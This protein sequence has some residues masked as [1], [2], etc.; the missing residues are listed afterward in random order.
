MHFPLRL[1]NSARGALHHFLHL[2]AL[3][4]SH[5]GAPIRQVLY[6]FSGGGAHASASVLC[7]CCSLHLRSR[8]RLAPPT[9]AL[10]FRTW[11]LALFLHLAAHTRLRRC[12]ARVLQLALALASAPCTIHCG[13][14]IP[15]MVPCTIPAPRGP[16]IPR[17]AYA[18][19]IASRT[20]EV[21]AT[22]RPCFA[23]V[24]CTASGQARASLAC[25]RVRPRTA[26]YAARADAR[27]GALH[28]PISFPLSQGK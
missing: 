17:T 7:A 22:P 18:T 11:C 9:V 6:T 2:T 26:F 16:P 4:S 1:S 13:S 10:L 20:S 14:P 12:S 23:P 27:V 3:L 24:P 28:H 21:R 19:Q 15:H 25:T 5:H 8:R